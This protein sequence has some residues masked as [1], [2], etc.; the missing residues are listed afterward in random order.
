MGRQG[1][2]ARLRGYVEEEL[3]AAA[4]Y[5]TLAG[6]AEGHARQVLLELADGEERHARLWARA[7][8]RLGAPTGVDARPPTWRDRILAFVLARIGLLPVVPLLERREGAEIAEY[9]EEPHAP[10]GI[11]EEE[12][13]HAAMLSS[14]APSWRTRAS[15][16]LRAG[17]F[18]ASDGIVS[19]LALV[20]GVLGAAAD[21]Q[22]VVIAGVA[23]LLAGALS[24]AVGEYVSVASQREVLVGGLAGDES[25]D[26]VGNPWRAA[27]ASLATFASGAFVPLAPFLLLATGPAAVISLALTGL[28]LY[29]VGA[30]LTL[31][32]LRPAWR[33]GLRQLSLGY[34]AAAA[35]Y[36]IGQALGVA[37]S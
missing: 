37:V 5:R 23:G 33:S 22:A 20:M 35:T 16:T 32:T 15:G 13:Q 34:G 26:A 10:E 3:R 27:L 36:V 7:L 18:G 31:L 25:H 30:G 17:V 21:R 6:Q 4:T 9:S 24:M 14:L 12:R 1:D 19:N 11:V 8:D 29:G 28:V 2:V